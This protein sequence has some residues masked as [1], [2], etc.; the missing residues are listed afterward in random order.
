MKTTLFIVL[1]SAFALTTHAQAFR[2]PELNVQYHRARTAWLTG[3]S[4]LEAKARIDRV[5]NKLPDDTEALKLRSAILLE[6]DRAEEAHRDAA[7]AS[8]LSPEDGE[9]YVLVCETAAATDRMNLAME[10]LDTASNLF[11]AQI[12]QYVR[13]S[14]CALNLGQNTR[15]VSLARI[16]VAQ[17]EDNPRGHVQLARI[18]MQTHDNEAARAVLSK[19]IEQ[20][21]ITMG[22]VLADAQL[23]ALYLTDPL[24][25]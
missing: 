7:R 21:I 12:E 10:A 25:Q 18:F 8:L 24:N 16:A 6:L 5:L 9:G 19:A 22:A 11:L 15:A 1:L 3:N 20:S 2:P 13:L 17:D 23:A 14:T 4:L